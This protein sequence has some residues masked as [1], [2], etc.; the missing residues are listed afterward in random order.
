MACEAITACRMESGG[1]G[2]REK[3]EGRCQLAIVLVL[4]RLVSWTGIVT[5]EME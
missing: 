3:T 2:A 5:E 1:G 4:V